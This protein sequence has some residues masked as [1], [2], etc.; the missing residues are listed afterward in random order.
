MVTAL[1]ARITPGMIDAI[2]VF[3]GA[4]SVVGAHLQA[5]SALLAKRINETYLGFI[6]ETFGIGAPLAG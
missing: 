3:T 5:F 4:N 6:R 2:N 1:A